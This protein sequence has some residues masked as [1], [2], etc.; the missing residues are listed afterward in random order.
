[1]VEL[2]AAYPRE[3][4]GTVSGPY[5]LLAISDTGSGMDMA[6]QAH[7]F[8]PFFTTKGPDKGTGLGLATVH[9]IVHQSGGHIWVYSE[10]GHGATFKIYLPQ[11]EEIAELPTVPTPAELPHGSGTILLVE[12]EAPVRALA[13]R[14]LCARGY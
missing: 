8:E 4:V 10:P 14:V 9:G 5:I 11:I 6:T 13:A 7:I 2:D 1:N 3:H 12:D